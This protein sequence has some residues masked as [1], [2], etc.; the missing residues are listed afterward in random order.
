MY[1]ITHLHNST[2]FRKGM[3]FESDDMTV[4]S[5][6]PQTS[7]KLKCHT[8]DELASLDRQGGHLFTK[9]L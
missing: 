1:Y 7:S 6:E 5:E 3:K 9:S 4:I 8:S 2:A